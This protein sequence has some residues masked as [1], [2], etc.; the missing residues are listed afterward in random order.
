M[1]DV[2]G[3]LVPQVEPPLHYNWWPSPITVAT[4]SA[5]RWACNDD[6]GATTYQQV[7]LDVEGSQ[8]AARHCLSRWVPE[9]SAVFHTSGLR[10]VCRSPWGARVSEWIDCIDIR[11][12]AW[13]LTPPRSWEWHR[14]GSMHF[15]AKHMV[16][17]KAV[18]SAGNLLAKS[19][20]CIV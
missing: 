11:S 13:V 16:R 17:I 14:T 20:V 18:P 19:V 6:Y 9:H 5:K 1:Q 12:Q 7:G 15:V 10:H 3:R 2:K 8:R 4:S